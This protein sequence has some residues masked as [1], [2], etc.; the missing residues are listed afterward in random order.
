M[1]LA[2]FRKPRGT[3]QIVGQDD[4]KNNLA[5]EPVKCV[6]QARRAILA[7][8]FPAAGLS[9]GNPRASK[10]PGRTLKAVVAAGLTAGMVAI[11]A[12][13]VSHVP[14]RCMP[15]LV[16]M[17]LTEMAKDRH[18]RTV[19]AAI[20]LNTMEE[21]ETASKAEILE[22]LASVAGWAAKLKDLDNKAYVEVDAFYRC[23]RMRDG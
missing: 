9:A 21:F 5:G 12:P 17:V 8:K 20:R 15:G 18:K 22:Q 14:E 4:G 11:A 7:N 2:A 6:L 19:G 3:R 13:A 1:A 10:G 16:A 23:M